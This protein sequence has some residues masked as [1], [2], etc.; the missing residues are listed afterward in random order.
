MARAGTTPDSLLVATC[1]FARAM[2]VMVLSILI[3]AS[4]SVMRGLYP[5]VLRHAPVKTQ[6]ERGS[7]DHCSRD[8]PIR[9]ESRLQKPLSIRMG[10]CR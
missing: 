10:I 9:V 6:P 3:F 2:P 4:Q 7:Q 1:R 8:C 5:Q